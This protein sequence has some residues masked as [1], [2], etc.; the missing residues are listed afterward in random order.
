MTPR[1]KTAGT[2]GKSVPACELADATTQ[3]AIGTVA[4]SSGTVKPEERQFRPPAVSPAV[5]A[6][7]AGTGGDPARELEVL[8]VVQAAVVAARGG[9]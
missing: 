4:D 6:P 1:K 3:H 7:F 8:R 5:R 2:E 9:R